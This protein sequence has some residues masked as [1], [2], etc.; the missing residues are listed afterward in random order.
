MAYSRSKVA[1][2]DNKLAII[3]PADK[4]QHA[5]ICVVA[6]NPLKAAPVKVNLPE[7]L[8]LHIELV[9]VLGEFQHLGVH[10]VLLRQMP[11]K[12]G[13]PLPLNE[14]TELAALEQE[15][16]ARMSHP[17]AKEG[18]E[19]G[20]L[21][22]VVTRHLVDQRALAMHYLVMGQRQH[23]I[24]AEGV[25][26]GEGNLVMMPLPV[27]RIKAEIA[28][29]V[30]HPAHIPL[31]V[32]AHAAHV[33]RLGDVRPGGGLLGDHQCLRILP[34]YGLVELVEEVYGLQVAVAAVLV[35]LPLPMLPAIVQIQHIGHC[36]NAQSVNM[37][38]IHPENRVGNQEALYL[39]AAII[40]VGG[41]PACIVCTLRI[42]RLIQ[43]APIK[44]TETRIIL[45]EVPRH[46]VHDYADACLMCLINEITQVIR[47]TETAGSGIIAGSLI[48]PGAFIRVLT[49]R[50][51][52]DMGV[53]HFLGIVH[54][55][56]R[57][58]T[59]GQLI[60]LRGAA[61]GAQMHLVGQHRLAVGLGAL[62]L[63]LPLS[64]LPLIVVHII[65]TGGSSR[66]HLCMISIRV[67]LH[68]MRAA[69]LRHDGIL[70]N[71]PL[72]DTRNEDF[73]YLAIVNLGHL[74]DTGVP[75]IELADYADLFGIWSP[76]RK[77][78]AFLPVFLGQMRSQHLIGSAVST[79][80]KQKS[81]VFRQL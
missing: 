42:V 5:V 21:L 7:L 30:I 18:T 29:G 34:E 63:L 10:L 31:V 8:V 66:S 24:L 11:V 61:P 75:V 25:H 49:E 68:D 70:V 15:L 79:L 39:G 50:H 69:M 81:I 51:E 38:L 48:A 52:L 36:I 2:S 45:A 56:F 27:D 4:G 3:G 65:D 32:K 23:E 80:M 73:P 77:A 74:V 53:V 78:H 16:L 37:V 58:I 28:E 13:I 46:P 19:A 60:A 47:R 71:I 44:V 9:E 1:D 41:T 20:K 64:I 55:L 35:R 59:I 62:L 57:H 26:H 33:D 54:Q 40:K 6:V 14:L 17:V 67:S 72:L 12:A 76:Y 22:P 43:V